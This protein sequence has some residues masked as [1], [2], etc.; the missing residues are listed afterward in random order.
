MKE[1]TVIIQNWEESERGWGTRPDG[2]TIHIDREQHKKYV[3][4]YNKTFNNLDSAPDEYTRVCGD[5][6]EVECPNDLYKRIK[7]ETLK[8]VDRRIANSI[9]GKGRLFSTRPLR[10]LKEIDVQFPED[11]KEN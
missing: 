2:W 1:K 11:K 9:W 5:P 3:D 8:K 6:I 10:A 7:K 4:W